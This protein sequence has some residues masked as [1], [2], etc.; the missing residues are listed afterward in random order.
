MFIRYTQYKNSFFAAMLSVFGNLLYA[1]GAFFIIAYIGGLEGV[2]EEMS[3]I[4]VLIAAVCSGAAGYGLNRLAERIAI[5]PITEIHTEVDNLEDFL[6]GKHYAVSYSYQRDGEP[7]CGADIYVRSA[8]KK[9]LSVFEFVSDS[10]ENL[11][12]MVGCCSAM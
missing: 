6:G 3:F 1:A 4:E 10:P 8:D 7:E 2:R 11:E 5:G 12:Q 9:Y